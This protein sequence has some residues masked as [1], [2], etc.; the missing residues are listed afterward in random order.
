M[1]YKELAE[2]YELISGSSKRLEKTAIIST[3]LKKGAAEE[4]EPIMLLLQGRIFPPGDD[5]KIGVASR[6]VIKAI[7]VATGRSKPRIESGWNKLGDL[8]LV[9][10]KMH[11]GR[12]QQTLFGSS[13]TTEKVLSNLAKVA[14]LEGMGTV[15]RKVKLIAELLGDAEPI[16]SRYIVRTVL[17]DL[18]VGVG[19]GIL[20][21]A[22]VWAF[23]WQ[24]DEIYDSESNKL[25][26]DQEQRLEYN[27]LVESVQEAY[28]L[29]SDLGQVAKLCKEKGAEGLKTLS[30]SPGKPVKV[31]LFQKAQDIEDMFERLG[32]PC[33]LE[34]KY[35]GFRLQVHKDIDHIRLFTRRQEDVTEQ[36]PDVV[37]YIKEH[38]KAKSM[39]MDTETVG[40]STKTGRYL[41]FQS[42][43][44]R[45]KR[46]H[47]IQEIAQKFPVEVNAFDLL[48]LDG[49]NML[50]KPFRERR[51]ALKSMIKP[52]ER[53]IVCSELLA[54]ADKKEAEAFYKRSLSLG[55]EGMMGKRMDAPYKPG[56]RVGF[57]VKLKP[58]MQSLELV[59]VAAEWG[60]GKRSQ[61]LTSYTLACKDQDDNLLEIGKVSTGLKE[62]SESGESFEL[63]TSMLK[64][65]VIEEKGRLVRLKPKVIIEVQYE[66]IQRSPTYKSGYALRFPRFIR[67][68]DDRSVSDI[69]TLET[70]E[71]LYD[72]QRHR[73]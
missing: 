4:L 56:S 22:I 53:K 54:T 51:E 72:L 23:L 10:E 19:E 46:K 41:P 45:I 59:I 48:Y 64:P 70:V 49:T 43:S 27:K 7:Q 57:G 29:T 31:M 16:E 5:K 18:R 55:N 66:E 1:R 35:D 32:K 17:E 68:R 34:Y 8:G 15:D 61:W 39:I 33:A 36:F 28:D 50:K 20:R 38:V 63:L 11:E 62:L 26:L 69:D 24:G 30:L 9:A 25:T 42:I 67:L 73:R 65:L 44:Q 47:N 12:S 2:A 6:I 3:L 37:A 21:D 71:E 40:F 58:V 14:S 13:L 52:E 60:E